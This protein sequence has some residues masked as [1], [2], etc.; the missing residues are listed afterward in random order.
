MKTKLSKEFV[1]HLA[2]YIND[3]LNDNYGPDVDE[4]LIR[5]AEDVWEEMQVDPDDEDS[6]D[7]FEGVDDFEEDVE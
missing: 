2:K 4:D 1:K 6:D 5:E 7:F 3:A